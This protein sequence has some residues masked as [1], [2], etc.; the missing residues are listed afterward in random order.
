MGDQ[1]ADLSIGGQVVFQ[2]RT[3]INPDGFDMGERPAR[4]RRSVGLD[5]SVVH[6]LDAD[7]VHADILG[8][9]TISPQGIRECL[10][11]GTRDVDRRDLPI[12]VS[13]P[14]EMP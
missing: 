14:S 2:Q 1:R 4:W 6:R 12:S 3:A 7:G 9:A 10:Q 11:M 13:E 8:G 5:A